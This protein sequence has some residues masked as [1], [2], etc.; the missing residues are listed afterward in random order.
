MH[1]AVLRSF[2]RPNAAEW[3]PEVELLAREA[4]KIMAEPGPRLVRERKACAAACFRRVCGQRLGLEAPIATASASEQSSR[5]WV[6]GVH[7]STPALEG[8]K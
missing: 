4:R 6:P 1:P 5:T 7:G 8:P 3:E 2:V